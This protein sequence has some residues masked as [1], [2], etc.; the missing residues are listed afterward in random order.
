MMERLDLNALQDLRSQT[1]VCG[2]PASSSTPGSGLRGVP[3][4][5]VCCLGLKSVGAACCRTCS[6]YE[7]LH[8][9]CHRLGCELAVAVL[10]AAGDV[11][12]GEAVGGAED[13]HAAAVLHELVGPA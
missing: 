13:F 9:R 2:Q 11:L 7:S 4:G 10:D 3:E 8:V 12:G 5:G 6:A 1:S